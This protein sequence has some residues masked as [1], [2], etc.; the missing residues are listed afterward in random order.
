MQMELIILIL[1]SIGLSA[2]FSGME[3]AFVSS[4]KLCFEMDKGNSLS[5]KI[6]S[7][8]LI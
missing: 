3:I 8:F 1:I 2:Y 6:L 4:N 7:K 5:G